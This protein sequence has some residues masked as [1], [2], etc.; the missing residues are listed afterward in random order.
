M[1]GAFIQPYWWND[2]EDSSPARAMKVADRLFSY[3]STKLSA[4]SMTATTSVQ[5]GITEESN[6]Q[7][8]VL[9]EG[10]YSDRDIEVLI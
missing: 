10:E 9:S 5:V 1:T 2:K 7:V 4:E 6:I 3:V 8:D